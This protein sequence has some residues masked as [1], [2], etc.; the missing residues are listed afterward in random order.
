MNLVGRFRFRF[1][2]GINLKRVLTYQFYCSI[3]LCKVTS[4][5]AF[6]YICIYLTFASKSTDGS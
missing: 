3:A 2:L 1:E 6:G 5:L 4:P